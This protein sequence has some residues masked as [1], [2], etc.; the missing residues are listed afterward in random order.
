MTAHDVT[1]S[2]FVSNGQKKYFG[3]IFQDADDIGTYL[4]ASEIQAI[5]DSATIYGLNLIVIEPSQASIKSLLGIKNHQ[6]SGINPYD[7]NYR[8]NFVPNDLLLSFN[9]SKGERD[10]TW[11]YLYNFT[12]TD[13]T[14]LATYNDT[15]STHRPFFSVKQQPSGSCCFAVGIDIGNWY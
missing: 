13:A 1:L 5:N 12:V 14:V 2:D 3:I 7:K 8:V 6:V 11:N 10:V 4:S 15:Q 9:G